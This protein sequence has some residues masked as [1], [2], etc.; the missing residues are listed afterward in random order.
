MLT[1]PNANKTADVKI[2]LFYLKCKII[3]FTRFQYL[4]RAPYLDILIIQLQFKKESEGEKKKK[5]LKK[6]L[7]NSPISITIY[8]KPSHNW[9]QFTTTHN[10]SQQPPVNLVGE[11]SQPH[12]SSEAYGNS[13]FQDFLYSNCLSPAIITG[14]D[15][16]QGNLFEQ[17]KV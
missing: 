15:F 10:N 8:N 4:Q 3:H 7:S 16:Q 2:L 6:I 9:K 13:R 12:S 11:R 17:S 14:H 5:K 1:I